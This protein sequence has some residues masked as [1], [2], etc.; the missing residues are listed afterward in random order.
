MFP[1]ILRLSRETTLHN[2]SARS[3]SSCSKALAIRL[4]S[5]DG[6]ST[7][8]ATSRQE[9][10]AVA[11][12]LIIRFAAASA[13]PKYSAT[14]ITRLRSQV[15]SSRL[16]LVVRIRLRTSVG[17]GLRSYAGDNLHPW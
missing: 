5:A 16:M 6:A 13:S 17:V 3:R 8:A 7:V 9:D 12:S 10:V 14:E 4:T 15:P 2:S 11:T 1:L